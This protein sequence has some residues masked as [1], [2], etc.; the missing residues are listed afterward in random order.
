MKCIQTSYKDCGLIIQPKPKEVAS[1]EKLVPVRF[2]PTSSELRL[3]FVSQSKLQR[4]QVQYAL[5]KLGHYRSSIDGIWGKGTRR[6]L[7][8]FLDKEGSVEK[9]KRHLLDVSCE[10]E[11]SIKVYG[12]KAPSCNETAYNNSQHCKAHRWCEGLCGL[13]LRARYTAIFTVPWKPQTTKT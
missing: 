7:Q 12:T 3:Y 6:A 4:K 13:R 10:G 8:D 9:L 11:C 2:A 5:K 1:V